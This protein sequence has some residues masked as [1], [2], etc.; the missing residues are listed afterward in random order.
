[1]PDEDSSGKR[2]FTYKG[3]VGYSAASH[4]SIATSCE[5]CGTVRTNHYPWTDGKQWYCPTKEFIAKMKYK[6]FKPNLD[7]KQKIIVII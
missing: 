2:R 6:V 5:Q 3:K 4:A 7:Y 1:M